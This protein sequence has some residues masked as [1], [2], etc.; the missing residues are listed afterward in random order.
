MALLQGEDPL[1][2]LEAMACMTGACGL[3]P[4]Q[5]WDRDPIPERDLYP[6]KPTGS[7]MPLVWAHAEFLKL[8]IARD[9][10]RPLELLDAVWRRYKGKAPKAST[11]Y[12]REEVPFPALPAGRS[13]VVEDRQ[14]FVLHLGFDGWQKVEDRASVPLGL[15]MHGVRIDSRKLTLRKEL[16]FTRFF[17]EPGRW[18]GLDHSVSL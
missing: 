12:W 8:L 13:L 15:G 4:E 7:A 16:N 5:V 18:E 2:Y 17:T 1:P 11:W 9:S 3:I 14:P 10:K 6:G